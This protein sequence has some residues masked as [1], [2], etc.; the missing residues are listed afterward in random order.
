MTSET[1]K[2]RRR[3]ALGVLAALAALAGA[4]VGAGAGD[5]GSKPAAEASFCNGPLRVAAGRKVMVRMEGSATPELRGAARAG[6]IG[7][8]ILFPPAGIESQELATELTRVQRAAA[9]GG[10]PGLLVA[11]DQEGGIVKRLPA[12]PPQASPATLAQGG[13]TGAARREGVATG[14]ALRELG[15]DVNL[16]PVLD[17]PVSGRQFMAPRAFGFEPG[18]VERLGLAFAAGQRAEGVAATAK[19]FPGLGRAPANTDLTPTV[20][21][22]SEPELE[23]DLTPFR[24]AVGAGID[25]VMVSSASYPALGTAAP[26]AL[27]PGIAKG[28]LRDRLGFE[29]VAISDDLLAP[30][31]AATRPIGEA[32]VLAAGAGIDLLLVARK[33]APGI[34]RELR[35]ALA[36][37]ELD[38]TQLRES[39]ARIT[40]L[41]ARLGD[42]GPR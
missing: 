21:G 41:K 9:R 1:T 36:A 19:H 38:E 2:R 30:A 27:T 29:G 20:V 42:G 6:E 39:C 16:A 7:G 34:A 10:N 8:V 35:M 32:A 37:G 26:A 15:I 17:V 3:N 31:I 28:L 18:Q 23:R 24:A 33:N 12:L 4:L 13:D 5:D 22:A 25:L 40:E 11:I 14:V